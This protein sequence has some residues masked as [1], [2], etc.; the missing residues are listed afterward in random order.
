MSVYALENVDLYCT[1]A[2]RA[3]V[4]PG[5]ITGNARGTGGADCTGSS[6]RNV[7]LLSH[8]FSCE[9]SLPGATTRTPRGN[10]ESGVHGVLDGVGNRQG[11]GDVVVI[12]VSPSTIVQVS[13]SITLKPKTPIH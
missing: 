2:S 11:K 9:P 3:S 13:R 5:A 6:G 12:R 7:K 10:R 1:A 8:S 4:L